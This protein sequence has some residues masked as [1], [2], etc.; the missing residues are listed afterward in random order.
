[1]DTDFF[2][3]LFLATVVSL[4]ATMLVASTAAA[5]PDSWRAE[6]AYAAPAYLDVAE[7]AVAARSAQTSVG[8][9]RPDGYRTD[10]S[11]VVGSAY[12]DAFE[13][14]VAAHSAETVYEPYFASSSPESM[15]L[16]VEDWVMQ[17]GGTTS[18]ALRQ[19]PDGFQPQLREPTGAPAGGS[20][21]TVSWPLVGLVGLGVAL[22]AVAGTAVVATRTGRRVAHP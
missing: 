2:T 1:M 13:R 4:A 20:D 7:R 22:L 6:D 11:G 12:P 14:A 21:G 8:T 3:R 5:R 19:T 17:T 16:R 9:H 15:A 18:S 10:L